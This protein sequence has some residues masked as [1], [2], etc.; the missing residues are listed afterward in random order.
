MPNE[1][2][3]PT[4]TDRRG[5][6]SVVDNLLPFQVRRWYYLYAPAPGVTRAGHRHHRTRQALVCLAGACEVYVHD[7][8]REHVFRLGRPDRGLILEAADWH[9]IRDF[10]PA[11]VL[12]VLASESYDPAD[13]I[14]E[15]Y[16]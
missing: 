14:D 8:I 7:G 6:L 1:I 4:F 16:P 12:L 2:D 13:Y 10:S 9:L 5:S 15:P 11:A 3:I